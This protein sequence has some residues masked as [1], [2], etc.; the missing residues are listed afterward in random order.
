LACGVC[1]GDVHAYR[2]RAGL[3]EPLL[4]GH[5]GTG[6]VVAVGSDLDED[7]WLGQRV[8]A[9]GGAY[10][11][12]FLTTPDAVVRLS[13]DVDPTLA[14]GEPIACCVHASWRFGVQPGDHVAIVGCGFMGLV[15]MQ[16]ARRLGAA[17]V[18]AFEPIVERREMALQLGADL[19]HPPKR[20]D[21]TT[22]DVVIE[23]T[24]VPE[25][26]TLSG[27]LVAQHGRLI[28]IGYHQSNGGRRTVDMQQWNYKAIDVVN[29]HVR[30]QDEKWEAMQAGM[31]LLLE[32]DIF[33][34]PLV[35]FYPLADVE[36]AFIDV[37]NRK[38]GVFKAVLITTA[39]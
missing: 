10:A 30:R 23:A 13:R 14:L 18:A 31:A 36:H 5:E 32:G 20:V 16:L 26:L 1:E 38:P 15:C 21:D 33:L 3:T 39:K 19:A 22:F 29:G 2:M 27:D 24:G 17:H 12:Y 7:A 34:E 35:T 4:L 11:D 6:E 28:I 8:T 9:L 37:V 25:A